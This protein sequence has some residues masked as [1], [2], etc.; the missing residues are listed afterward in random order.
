MKLRG[1]LFG[2]SAC[3]HVGV[4][5]PAELDSFL[6]G[7]GVLCLEHQCVLLLDVSSKRLCSEV[8]SVVSADQH[9]IRFVPR[10]NGLHTIDVRFNSSH[11]PGS[12]FK[13][14]VGDLGQDGDPGLVSAVGPGLERGTTGTA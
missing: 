6:I 3:S 2:A 11:I 12:P 7:A 10:E 4:V 5:D 14:R 9:A 8:A 1:L 13:I